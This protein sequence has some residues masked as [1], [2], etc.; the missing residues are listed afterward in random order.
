MQASFEGVCRGDECLYVILRVE[1]GCPLARVTAATGAAPGQELPCAVLPIDLV[2][3]IVDGEPAAGLWVVAAPRLAVDLCV[4]VLGT[5]GQTLAQKTVGQ[6][7]SKVSSRLLARKR[8]ELVAAVRGIERDNWSGRTNVR[9]RE[10]WP[11]GA[12]RFVW[13]VAVDFPS[14]DA[15]CG[16]ALSLLAAD[17]SRLDAH[18]LVM[19]DQT[20]PDPRDAGMGIR[21]VTFSAEVAE[22]LGEVCLVASMDGREDQ[23]G[24][25]FVPKHL[26]DELLG[27]GRYLAGGAAGDGAYERWF[28][29]HRATAA[30][31][32]R[33]R[34]AAGSP[35]D[36]GP[37]FS[38]VMPA[39]RTPEAFLAEAIR[40]VVAQSWPRW[41]LIVVNAS[42]EDE[43]MTRVLRAYAAEPRLRVV[44]AENLSIAQNT[45]AGIAAATGDYVCFLDHDDVLEPD[46]LWRYA[47][48]I[49]RHPQADLLY[50][51]ED[52]LRDGHP[53]CPAMKMGPQLSLLYSYNYVTHMLAVSRRALDLT[54]RSGADVSGAQ[55]Y[56]LTLRAFEVAREVMHVPRVLY[57][58]REH[59]GSTA[60]GSGQKPYAH[61]AGRL[62]LSRHLERR[63]IAARVEDGPLP[64]TYRV[65]Y[66]LPDPA[67]LASIV[68]PTKDH[69]NLLRACVTS[70]LERTTYPNYE[71]VLVE[72][73]STEAQTFACYQELQAADARVRVVTWEPG[74][75]GFNY[76]ALCNFGAS[77]A[78][79]DVLVFLNNDTE[80]IAAE[81]LDEMVGQLQRPEVGIVGA[82]LLFQD[83]LVQHCGVVANPAGD[84]CHVNQNLA[85]DNMGNGYVAAFP[86]EWSMVTGACQALTRQTF[87]LLGGFDERL[88]VGFND[89]DLCLAACEAGLVCVC[90]PYALLHHREFS[91]RGREEG[92]PQAKAR[93][94]REK[95]YVSGKHPDF[96]AGGDPALNPN[97]EPWSGHWELGW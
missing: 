29:L 60:D 50:C 5:D 64:Y 91:S 78:S 7:A 3:K 30:D 47:E 87:G 25:A 1:G 90:T 58:W 61:E 11:A 43:G 21:R 19:E 75:D 28:D 95:A 93:L 53:A 84:N 67:P 62:A 44:Q 45:N 33:Q 20:L 82:K 63:G 10:A 73:G 46:A 77:K 31:L 4:Q 40:S 14:S 80:V 88:A 59:A 49:R 89:S 96:Y 52:R 34:E 24:F 9:L 83:G 41:E 94:L 85:A 48:E 69:A 38:V 15:S 51:D 54:Q 66:A 92:N 71:L 42:P 70:V 27:R 37:T 6:L 79:G 76:S 55:D 74:E 16:V 18:P 56:D 81:W 86:T 57:H 97:L 13:R 72:N 68:I 8:P 36:A 35:C 26:S 39:F 12:G 22:G 17:G 32:A 65:R 2:G 23:R